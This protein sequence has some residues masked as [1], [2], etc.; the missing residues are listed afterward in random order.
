MDFIDKFLQDPIFS[1]KYFNPDYLFDRG[2]KFGR[3]GYVHIFQPATEH[4][5]KFILSLLAIFFIFIISYTTVRMFEIRRKEHKHL[6]HE[7]A[8][9]AHHQAEKERAHGEE[10]TKNEK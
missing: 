7:I 2:V 3:E 10:V 9:Y 5:I 8:E 1:F 6:Q 4:L